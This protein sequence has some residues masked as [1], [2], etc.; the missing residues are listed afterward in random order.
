MLPMNVSESESPRVRS[1]SRRIIVCAV[2][3]VSAV[4]AA[5]AGLQA[6][7]PLR[8][9]YQLI[10][11]TESE[12]LLALGAGLVAVGVGLRRLLRG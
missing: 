6:A 11:A 4:I 8:S 12:L 7:E 3:F 10:S 1:V 9:P 5:V 2:V